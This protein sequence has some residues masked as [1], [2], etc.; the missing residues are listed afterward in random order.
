[1]TAVTLPEKRKAP[2][3]GSN[4][5]QTDS[6]DGLGFDRYQDMDELAP[7]DVQMTTSVEK[8]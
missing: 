7:K 4:S 8:K 3:W 2:E 1:V 5:R 6:W